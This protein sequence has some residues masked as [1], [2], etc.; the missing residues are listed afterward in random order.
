MFALGNPLI[1]PRPRPVVPFEGLPESN[2]A[3]VGADVLV[4]EGEGDAELKAEVGAD[5][6][7][8]VPGPVARGLAIDCK[9]E[10]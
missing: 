7:P 9:R 6:L 2:V 1:P 4:T 8:N 5:I 10:A 3:L